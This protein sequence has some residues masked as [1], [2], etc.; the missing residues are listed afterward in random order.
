MS[1]ITG[2]Y[3]NGKLKLDKPLKT[4]RPIRVKLTVMEDDL[5]GLK[6]S[7]FSFVETQQLLKDCDS[8]FAEEV[9][10]ERRRAI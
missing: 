8:S 3:H 10:D 9:V 5:G 7:D 1:T 2:T 6:T 4:K